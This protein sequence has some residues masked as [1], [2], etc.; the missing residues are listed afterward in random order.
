MYQFGVVFYPQSAR[1]LV[2]Y[3]ST[4]SYWV[5]TDMLVYEDDAD[6]LALLSES[7]E[8]GFDGGGV[9]LAVDDEKVLLR[10]GASRNMLPNC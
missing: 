2:H 6:I 1:L 5:M 9:S 4:A 7:V 3:G 10:V 8:C